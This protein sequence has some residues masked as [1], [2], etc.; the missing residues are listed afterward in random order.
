[1]VI[2]IWKGSSLQ[3]HSRREASPQKVIVTQANSTV[4]NE[5]QAPQVNPSTVSLVHIILQSRRSHKP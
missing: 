1:M 5:S 3:Q 2:I 4:T